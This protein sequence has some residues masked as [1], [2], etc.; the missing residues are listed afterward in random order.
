MHAPTSKI[1]KHPRKFYSFPNTVWLIPHSK[2]EKCEKIHK[3]VL[4]LKIRFQ[5]TWVWCSLEASIWT[6]LSTWLLLWQVL[7]SLPTSL[8]LTSHVYHSFS[9]SSVH[10][11]TESKILLSYFFNHNRKEK[12][13]YNILKM[14]CHHFYSHYILTV[15][16]RSVVVS[17]SENFVSFLTCLNSW[18]LMTFARDI[19]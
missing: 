4:V 12:N 15:N 7:Y 13:F 8:R 11:F 17:S 5:W 1:S 2:G 16:C 6:M 9:N 10:V 18:R 14:D 19:I 3:Y